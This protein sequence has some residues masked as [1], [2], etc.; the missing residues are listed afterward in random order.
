MRAL[1]V[2]ESMWGNTER[3]AQAIAAG[4]RESMEVELTEVIQAPADPGP[5]VGLIVAGGPTHAFSMSRTTTRADALHRGAEHGESEIGLREW[6][7]GLPTGQH[8]QRIATFDTRVG[9]MRH[10]P[11]SAAKAAAKVAHRHGFERAEHVESFYVDDMEGPCSRGSLPGRRRGGSRSVPPR[12]DNDA[13]TRP[14][15]MP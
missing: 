13:E 15:G 10:L 2:Y 11:G 4:L 14:E 6:L 9:K 12:S 8:P 5:E 1:V 3:V 7:D